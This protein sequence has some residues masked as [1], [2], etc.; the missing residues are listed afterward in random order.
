RMPL[1][2]ANAASLQGTAS[3]KLSTG[4]NQ[5]SAF[6]LRGV[7]RLR[8]LGDTLDDSKK[9]PEL[10]VTN[11]SECFRAE[12]CVLTALFGG[13]YAQAAHTPYQSARVSGM[14]LV[15]RAE[16]ASSM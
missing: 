10:I 9:L 15:P 11:L 7:C 1:E 14:P 5:Q 12:C 4:S 8:A 13:P 3:P 16:G 2:R 6:S